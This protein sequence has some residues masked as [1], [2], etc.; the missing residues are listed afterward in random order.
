MKN[1]EM[2]HVKRQ[3]LFSS[4]AKND[5]DLCT[6]ACPYRLARLGTSQPKAKRLIAFSCCYAHKNIIRWSPEPGAQVRFLLGA[7]A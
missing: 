2:F 1:K 6:Q 3:Y 7:P 4:S 5:S